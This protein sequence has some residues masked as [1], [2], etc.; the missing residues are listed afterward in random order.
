[1]DDAADPDGDPDGKP[2]SN[3]DSNRNV[4]CSMLKFNDFD[5]DQF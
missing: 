1:M 2:E 3:K 4:E 5:N